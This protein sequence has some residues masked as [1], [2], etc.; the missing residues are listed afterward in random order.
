MHIIRPEQA[1]DGNGDGEGGEAGCHDHPEETGVAEPFLKVAG[2]HAGKHHAEGHEGGADGIVGSL[3][4]AFGEMHHVEHVGGET[5]AIAELLDEDAEADDK[6][7]VRLEH[8]Q[9]DECQ[10]REGHAE[11]HRPKRPLQ[12]QAGSGDA[13]DDAAY[14]ERGD[15][16]SPVDNA[17]IFRGEAQ[18]ADVLWIKQEGIHHLQEKG[19]RKTIQEHE[20]DGNPYMSFL[21]EGGEGAA[22]FAENPDNP[23]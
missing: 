19:F 12:A 8:A 23:A 22:E 6:D 20:K 1:A 3:E 11:S 10:A 2:D 9:I 5:E 4:F 18:A 15:T 21:E 13:S 16:Y 17:H 14:G 7:T